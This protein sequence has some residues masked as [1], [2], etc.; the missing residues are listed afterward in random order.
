MASLFS[1]R[2]KPG[3][4]Q[5]MKSD[6]FTIVGPVLN[7]GA[8]CERILRHLPEWF[9]H[10]QTVI[11]YCVEIDALPTFLINI[12]NQVCG[13]ISLKKHYKESAELYVLAIL[14][15]YHNQ[16]FGRAAVESVTEYCRGQGI[17]YLQIKTVGPSK[18]W[19]VY[20]STR[21]FYE[22]LGFR[23]LEEFPTLW[24]PE[25]QCLQM[26]KKIL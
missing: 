9:D 12:Q 5:L 26:I 25:C 13:F 2:E 17:E 21:K 18:D 4:H 14:P 15:E 3:I 16:G 22:S 24:G 11:D 10:E 19:P 6:L 23:A 1:F 7:S 20:H 8:E